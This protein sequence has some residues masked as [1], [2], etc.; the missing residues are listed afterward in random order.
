MPSND[1]FGHNGYKS[2]RQVTNGNFF[3]EYPVK[4]AANFKTTTVKNLPGQ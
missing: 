2:T 4:T 1:R 3:Y